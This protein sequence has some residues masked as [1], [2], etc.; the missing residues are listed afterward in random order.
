MK[1]VINYLCSKEIPNSLERW[2]SD[3]QVNLCSS[4]PRWGCKQYRPP[5]PWEGLRLGPGMHTFVWF[6]IQPDS[7]PHCLWAKLQETLLWK[8][9]PLKYCL[10]Y[11]KNICFVL[12][13]IISEYMDN[14][15]WEENLCII[16]P[17]LLPLVL[18]LDRASVSFS[19]FQLT[20]FWQTKQ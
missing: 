5:A 15:H 2:S 9:H 17:N 16:V 4:V 8:I 11:P 6:R 12:E 3:F 10:F 19:V 20:K 7:D 14:P 1:E 13:V 18:V